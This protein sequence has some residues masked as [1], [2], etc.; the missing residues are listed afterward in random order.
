MPR[1][2]NGRGTH[3]FWFENGG[4]LKD[5]HRG[6]NRSVSSCE[7]TERISF[8]VGGWSQQYAGLNFVIVRGSGHEV[9]LHRPKEALAL[10]KA[11]IS[12]T[13]LTHVEF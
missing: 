1:I 10:F 5:V 4:E 7:L 2:M 12:G 3:T 9:A 6:D 8:A 13:P 11:F